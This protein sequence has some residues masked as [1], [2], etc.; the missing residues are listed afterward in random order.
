MMHNF[1]GLRGKTVV[2]TH[3]EALILPATWS[4]SNDESTFK[5]LCA[6]RNAGSLEWL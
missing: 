1:I 4:S 2:T 3:T 5:F 6:C